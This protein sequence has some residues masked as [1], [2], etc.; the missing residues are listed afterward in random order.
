VLV[1][2]AKFDKEEAEKV[3]QCAE[4]KKKCI[5]SSIGCG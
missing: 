1:R 2:T 3:L 5:L 4:E